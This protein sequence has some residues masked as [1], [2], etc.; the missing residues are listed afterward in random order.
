MKHPTI[1][2]LLVSLATVAGADDR[3]EPEVLLEMAP[4]E[5][6]AMPAFDAGRTGERK[7]M[8]REQI[9]ERRIWDEA[10]L[11]AM[12]SVPRHLFVPEGTRARAY[13][14][15]PL[16]IGHGQTISQPY[17]VAFMSEQL[18]VEAGDRVLEVGTGSGYQAA[19]L[20][21]MGVEVVSIEI[22]PELAR[23]AA[24]RLD[25]LGFNNVTVVS[26]DGYFGMPE[27]GPYD[28]IIV[29]AAADHVPPPL[30][31]QLEPGARMIIPV[32]RSGWQQN[33]LRVT[34]EPDGTT[35]SRNLMAVRFVP[36]TGDH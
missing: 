12:S 36:L 13:D 27:Y 25:E 23:S 5:Q 21:A 19:V 8:V 2:L 4:P 31:E 1:L 22:I 29:T 3:P 10:V 32:G 17:M 6:Q 28:G 24:G 34:K 14:D 18:E 15:L 16:P 35:R 9:R 30:L 33:L 26:G 20:A 7:A 11:D